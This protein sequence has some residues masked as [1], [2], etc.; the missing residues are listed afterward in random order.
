M[1]DIWSDYKTIRNFK[2][3]KAYLIQSN[4]DLSQFAVLKK[5]VDYEL[6]EP[7]NFRKI[8]ENYGETKNL[9]YMLK[10]IDKDT[11]LLKY[12]DNTRSFKELI[13]D[14]SRVSISLSLSYDILLIIMIDCL[15]GL[16]TLHNS[17]I[18]HDDIDPLNVLIEYNR[19]EIQRAIIID[20]GGSVEFANDNFKYDIWNLM[21]IFV[22]YIDGELYETI[23]I[24]DGKRRNFIEDRDV[25][26]IYVT[27]LLDKYPE[28]KIL[29]NVLIHIVTNIYNS[30]CD[31]ILE[32]ISNI[33][34]RD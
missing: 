18:S 27:S 15:Y 13:N 2:T 9:S 19:N 12:I 31:S 29:I 28:Y 20:L 4:I 14:R 23:G 16:R 6:D 22:E 33:K 10:Q 25:Y 30:T 8:Q 34:L 26:L 21:L 11:I 32:Y 1:T 24:I 17:D 7:L 3:N 5:L